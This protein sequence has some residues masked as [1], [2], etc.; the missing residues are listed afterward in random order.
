RR[1]SRVEHVAVR[2]T[3]GS[4]FFARYTR[5]E[6]C[7]EFF[8]PEALHVAL[9]EPIVVDLYFDHS[10]YAFRVSAKVISGRM[11]QA[12]GLVPGARVLFNKRDES[13]LQMILAHARGEDVDYRPG[14]E[15]RVYCRVPVDIVA[16]DTQRGLVTD[17]SLGG[18]RL[19]DVALVPL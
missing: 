8:L 15:M 1:S 13:I 18:A 2:V 12:E 3:D 19:H 4:M 17:L 7:H 10:G 9:D 6:D 11:T 14:A 5:R 16:P